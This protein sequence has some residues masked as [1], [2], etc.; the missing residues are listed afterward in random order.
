MN[1]LW[2]ED[3]VK[4]RKEVRKVSVKCFSAPK[5]FSLNLQNMEFPTISEDDNR[6]LTKDIGDHEIKEAINKCGRTKSPGPD[7]FNFLFLK[8][9]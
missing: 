2:C 8:H 7:K 6:L 9:N 1:G 5:Q 4:V 3:P